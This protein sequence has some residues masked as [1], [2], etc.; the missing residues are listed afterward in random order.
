MQ[1]VEQFPNQRPKASARSTAS[2]LAA[3]ASASDSESG[4]KAAEMPCDD[5]DRPRDQQD[6][7][8]HLGGTG[9]TG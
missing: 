8:R 9:V 5:L 3:A 4:G 6:T 2:A 7:S 1:L